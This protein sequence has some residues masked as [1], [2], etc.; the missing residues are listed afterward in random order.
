MGAYAGGAS[1]KRGDHA[2]RC[3]RRSARH[4]AV[5]TAKRHQRA[6]ATTSQPKWRRRVRRSATEQAPVACAASPLAAPVIKRVLVYDAHFSL[7]ARSGPPREGARDH[8]ASMLPRLRQRP[9]GR[10]GQLQTTAGQREIDNSRAGDSRTL[11][12]SVIAAATRVPH[13]ERASSA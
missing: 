13:G 7:G 6:L 11:T 1:E 4:A 5:R 3:P 2:S 10:R 9:G 12:R 8:R